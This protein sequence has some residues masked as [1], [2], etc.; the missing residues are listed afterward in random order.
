M[1]VVAETCDSCAVIYMQGDIV[2]Y[3]LWPMAAP[4]STGLLIP[5]P[6]LDVDMGGSPVP[7]LPASDRAAEYCSF[8][9]L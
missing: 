4:L 9:A 7:G 3:E 1:G 5:F 2:E 8:A 6:R